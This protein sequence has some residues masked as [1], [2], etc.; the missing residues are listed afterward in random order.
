MGATYSNYAM[1]PILYHSLLLVCML[2]TACNEATSITDEVL[3]THS[4]AYLKSLGGESATVIRQ[5]V[6]IR[7]VVTANDRLGE[8][9][10]QLVL[11]DESGGI[12]LSIEASELY[13]RYPIGTIIH[14]FCNGLTLH[15]YGGHIELGYTADAYGRI[16]IPAEETNRYLHLREPSTSMPRPTP[17]SLTELTPSLIDRY[18]RIDNVR[19]LT[20]RVAW[21]DDPSATSYRYRVEHPIA[22]EAGNTLHV[23]AISTCHYAKEPLPEGKGSL[24]G[25]IDYFNGRYTLRVI[26]YGVDF[27]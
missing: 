19:F 4:I 3:E 1:R 13:R 2:F 20:P 5:A 17:I 10:R 8:Y 14:L 21:C 15:N 22:D 7:G 18:V 23:E 25:I 16:G 6:V 27:R 12:T 24:Y 26:N 11:E 9:D